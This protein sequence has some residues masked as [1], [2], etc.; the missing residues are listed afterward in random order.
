M[1]KLN[2]EHCQKS[3]NGGTTIYESLIRSITRRNFLTEVA[4]GAATIAGAS[5]VEANAAT[6]EAKAPP[7]QGLKYSQYLFSDLKDPISTTLKYMDSRPAA[8]FRGAHQI[9]GAS[10]NMGWQVINSPFLMETM[11][12]F[13]F[14]FSCCMNIGRRVLPYV[15]SSDTIP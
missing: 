12:G 1:E 7:S 9:P 4:T 6:Q 8:Y 14:R 15:V 2:L 3:A 10:I 11:E 13:M 5:A